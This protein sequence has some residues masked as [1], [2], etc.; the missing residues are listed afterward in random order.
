MSDDTVRNIRKDPLHRGAM[1]RGHR[2]FAVAL[3]VF[4]IVSRTDAQQPAYE[5]RQITL[6]AP[7]APR[8]G[9]GLLS[10]HGKLWLLGGWNPNKSQREFFPRICNN[11]VWAST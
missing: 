6:K 2:P 10:Y 1:M 7:F 5:W 9:A 4:A 3:L 8:D 11:E